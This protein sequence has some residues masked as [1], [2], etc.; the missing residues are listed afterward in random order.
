MEAQNLEE[1]FLVGLGLGVTAQGVGA[2]MGG[3]EVNVEHLDCSELVED[4][5]WGQPG[6]QSTQTG[7]RVTCRQ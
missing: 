6:S 3:W 4:G 1:D 7:T 2:S 5:A